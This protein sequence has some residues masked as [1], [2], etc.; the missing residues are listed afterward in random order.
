MAVE[1]PAKR[2]ECVQIRY[3]YVG[4]VHSVDADEQS[5][6]ASPPLVRTAA[7]DVPTGSKDR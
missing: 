6:F 3:A 1:I 7:P 2:H 5:Q 4:H